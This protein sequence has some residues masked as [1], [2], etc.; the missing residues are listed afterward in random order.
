MS[1]Q[2]SGPVEETDAPVA[3]SVGVDRILELL[4]R[5]RLKIEGLLPN[6]SNYTF[7]A[8][9]KQPDLECLAVYKPQRGERP[10]WDFPRGTLFRREYAAFL[11][12]MAIGWIFVPPTVLRR[13]PHGMGALQLYMDVVPEAN[14]FSLREQYPAIFQR[15]CAFDYVVNNA[16]RKGG[17]CL[18]GSD[19][20]VWAID[21]GVTFNADFKLRTVIW[22]WAGEP[23]PEDVLAGLHRLQQRLGADDNLAATLSRLLSATE[24]TA[25][26]QRVDALLASGCFP[27]P[28]QDLPN[29]PWPLI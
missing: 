13:G 14:F 10:L 11:V 18:M 26:R 9:V 27:E 1:D 20:R 12:A 3:R 16:D 19:G 2:V 25:L 29:I 21:H 6:S 22:D 15:L 8:T 7:L 28:D 5:G 17:H 4:H 24:I 23:M